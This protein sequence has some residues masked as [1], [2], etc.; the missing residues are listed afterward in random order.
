MKSKLGAENVHKLMLKL[1]APAVIAM[2]A[3]GT[4]TTVSTI[5]IS[6]GIN[7]TAVGAVGIVFALQTLFHGFAQLVSIGA[8]SAISRSLGKQN[9]DYASLVATNSYMLTLLLSVLLILLVTRYMAPI[10]HFFG[11]NAELATPA[12]EYL[13][14]LKWTIP[15]NAIILLTSAIFRAEGNL[16]RSALIVVTDALLN[17]GFDY[18]FIFPFGLGLRGAGFATLAS[19]I[20]ASTLGLSYIWRQKS[21]IQFRLKDL[22]PNLKV[23][24][25]VIKVGF[26]AFARNASTTAFSLVINNTLRTLGGTESLIAFGAANRIVSFFFLPIMGVNQGFQPIASFN[27]GANEQERVRQS[28]KYALIYTTIIGLIASLVGLLIPKQI[29]GL[30]T[31]EQAAIDLGATILRL[32]LILFCTVGFQTVA[33]TLYQALGRGGPAL[34]FSIFKQLLLMIPLI[35]WLPH[36]GNLQTYGVWLSFP[37]A[38]LLA[39]LIVL[40]VLKKQFNLLKKA[41]SPTG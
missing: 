40:F 10:L 25:S 28:I 1:S 7:M 19:Q 33:S 24:W 16:K 14:I 18:L 8:A 20:I 5:M 37:I 29:I 6:R 2:I 23:L 26:S 11:A 31:S 38:E 15:L 9:K 22:R 17:I 4:Y 3:S 39:F 35:L 41:P 34:F 32:Q 30:L 13:N 36:L 21:L 27:Y 12:A